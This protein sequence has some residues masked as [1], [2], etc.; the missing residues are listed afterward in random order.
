MPIRRR[1]TTAVKFNPELFRRWDGTGKEPFFGAAGYTSREQAEAAWRRS[2]RVAWATTFRFNIPV[3]AAAYDGL[4]RNGWETLWSTWNFTQF[5]DDDARRV[6]DALAADGRAV[7]HFE[8]TDPQGA[9]AI[10]DFLMLWRADLD[11]LRELTEAC[12]RHADDWSARCALGIPNRM[13][14][15]GKYGHGADDAFTDTQQRGENR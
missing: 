11:T 10:H 14:T 13:S 1:V 4:T 3:A 9:A 8:K 15:A 7:D 5:D 2:R 12:A 6:L